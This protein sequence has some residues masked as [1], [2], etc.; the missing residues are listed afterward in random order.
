MTTPPRITVRTLRCGMPLITEVM[1]GMKSAAISW[2]LPCG[3]AHDPAHQPGTSAMWTELLLRGAGARTSREFADA[4]D[5]QGAGKSVSGGTFTMSISATVIGTRLLSTLPLLVDMVRSPRMDEDS[6][7]PSQDLC[8]QAIESLKD[9]PQ[10]RAFIA[11]ALRSATP[12]SSGASSLA[13]RARPARI[14]Q[15]LKGRRP[16]R[17]GARGRGNPA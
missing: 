6:I 12:V 8:I 4:L 14:P 10:E 7:S 11:A 9:N 1:G 13:V 16:S 5:E 2:S 15:N 3:C 17:H